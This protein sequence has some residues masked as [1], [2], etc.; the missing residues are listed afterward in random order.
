MHKKRVVAIVG[1]LLAV[2][3]VYCIE[4]AVPKHDYFTTRTGSLLNH[5]SAENVRSGNVHESVR[6]ES[7][8]GLQI[9]MRVLRPMTAADELLPVLILLGGYETGKDGVDLVGDPDGMAFAAIDYPYQGEQALDGFWESSSA[10]P[11]VQKA[12]L[13]SPPAV[14]LAVSWLLQ[15]S[16][17]DPERI[18]LVG[19]SLGVPFAAVAGAV[20]ER[21]SRVWLMHGGADN[22]SWVAHNARDRIENDFLRGLVARV[23]LFAVY[24]NSFQTQR[25]I[26]EIAPRPLIIVA[27]RSDDFV[28]RESQQAFIQAANAENVE[29]IWTEGRHIGPRRRQELQQLL[30]IVTQR[31]AGQ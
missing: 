19:V 20:D 21:I 23:A 16:W 30:E 27:A 6:L 26:P 9:D 28:P 1:V 31:I 22:V 24:G 2:F 3:V 14:S 10:I 4:L 11:A 8:T 12:F 17:I 29:L 13:D 7:S 18:E 5:D 15:Q 25:W